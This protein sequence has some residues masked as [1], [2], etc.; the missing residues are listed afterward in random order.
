MA[1][2]GAGCFGGCPTPGQAGPEDV[3]GNFFM[4]D[5]SFHTGEP[6]TSVVALQMGLS[7]GPT[8]GSTVYPELLAFDGQR[9]VSSCVVMAPDAGCFSD[10][11][12]T[13]TYNGIPISWDGNLTVSAPDITSVW[14]GSAAF[15]GIGAQAVQFVSVPEPAPLVL[16]AFAMV[17]LAVASRQ[18]KRGVAL[19]RQGGAKAA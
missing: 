19:S 14:V 16:L 15:G 1:A 8:F 17:G 9:L 4:F 6:V 11:S 2:N 7:T 5:V 12:L 3:P 10:V 13:G 18:S